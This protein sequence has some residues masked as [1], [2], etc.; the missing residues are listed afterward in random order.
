[1]RHSPIRGTTKKPCLRELI[2]GA[3]C[4][5]NSGQQSPFFPRFQVLNV[6]GNRPEKEDQRG[7]AEGRRPLPYPLH[8]GGSVLPH[9]GKGQGSNT[10]FQMRKSPWWKTREGNYFQRV[11]PQKRKSVG[12][13]DKEGTKVGDGARARTASLLFIRSN[14]FLFR[15]GGASL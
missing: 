7:N 13:P 14:Y 1:M 15:K 4:S 10:G 2:K 6:R 3:P 5:Y 12:L 9:L 11:E 8:G